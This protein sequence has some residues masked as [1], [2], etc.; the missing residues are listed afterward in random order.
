MRNVVLVTAALL[1]AAAGPAQAQQQMVF[2]V[3]VQQTGEDV[4]F[5]S[6]PGD[7]QVPRDVDVV[8][9]LTCRP[10]PIC[11]RT[12]A[13]VLD[14][15]ADGTDVPLVGQAA[16]GKQRFTI[17]A[18]DVPPG[19]LMK[20]VVELDGTT[21]ELRIR[22][23]PDTATAHAFM[24]RSCDEQLTLEGKFYDAATNQ[25]V[26]VVSPFG[27]VLARPDQP[28][29]ENDAVAVYVV[30]KA[31]DVV[32]VRIRRS[33]LA[34]E[35][36][37]ISIQ[38]FE[39]VEDSDNKRMNALAEWFFDLPQ[40][41]CRV[42]RADLGDFDSGR[43]EIQITRVG[44]TDK[45]MGKFDLTVNPLYTGAFTLG[46]VYTWNDDRTFDTLADRTI[47]ETSTG[48]ETHYVV[49]YSHFLTGRR[50]PEKNGWL[51]VGAVVAVQPDELLDHAF[52]GGSVDL[53][54]SI[55]VVGGFHGA[56]VTRLNS[57]S[58]LRVGDKLPSG[59]TTVPTQEEW[60]W[61]G[62]VGITLDIRAAAGLISKAANALLKGP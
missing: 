7:V 13:V 45:E 27:T 60:K 62:F 6:D 2:P 22:T 39:A 14:G 52:I 33:S 28:I 8:L 46:P 15:E 44:E 23:E 24:E 36:G 3:G 31:A 56:E 10:V 26:F 37:I 34:R 55:F 35:G 53:F 19:P 58:G 48:R 43:G 47:H 5:T 38:G 25:A 40:E 42:V 54:G 50:D 30:G 4:T 21:Q 61:G 12:E 20:V 18:A 9:E 1:A 11:A 51:G 41:Q 32:N 57:A 59:F 49:A 17:P 29:D 16:G